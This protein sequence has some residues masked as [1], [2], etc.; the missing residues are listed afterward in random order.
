MW[1]ILFYILVFLSMSYAVYVIVHR[2]RKEKYIKSQMPNLISIVKKTLHN[3]LVVDDDELQQELI[4]Q[5]LIP[6]DCKVHHAATREEALALINNNDYD[7]IFLDI[8]LAG[9]NGNSVLRTMRANNDK[10]SVVIVTGF[11]DSSVYKMS[12]E[13]NAPVI[14][15][16]DLMKHIDLWSKIL[17]PS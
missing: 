15:K 8:K 13:L 11:A 1:D 9:H 10:T 4:K 12:D 16:Q 5:K 6:I 14:E 2:Q 7:L 3:V 17:K